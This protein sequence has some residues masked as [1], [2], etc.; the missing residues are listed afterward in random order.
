[1]G[2]KTKIKL[3]KHVH[4]NLK[5]I[6]INKRGSVM[7]KLRPPGVGGGIGGSF[8]FLNGTHNFLKKTKFIKIVLILFRSHLFTN[9]LS[10]LSTYRKNDSGFFF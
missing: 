1:M 7:G 9:T 10:Y 8:G 5:K 2:G 4:I 6:V 3:K